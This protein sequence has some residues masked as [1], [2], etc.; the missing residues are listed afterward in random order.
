MKA[1]NEQ[2]QQ[3]R[4]V[5][6]VDGSDTSQAA[7]SWAVQEAGHRGALVDAIH[8]WRIPA[9]EAM[10]S[11]STYMDWE[12]HA[13]EVLGFALQRLAEHPGV[14]LRGKTAEGRPGEVL[15]AEAGDPDTVLLVVGAR[16]RGP[17]GRLML[18][19]TGQFCV[20]RSHCP[21]VVVPAFDDLD[22]DAGV[23]T[24]SHRQ[25]AKGPG[26]APLMSMSSSW[27]STRLSDPP[28]APVGDTN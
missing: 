28:G 9:S 10:A 3:S 13:E 19:S 15:V 12:K 17:V 4:I 6:G 11:V 1:D 22:H 2:Q 20:H 14:V 18:G 27:P 24:G 7:L 21:V 16:H 26:S 5:V 8:A 23:P 25:A